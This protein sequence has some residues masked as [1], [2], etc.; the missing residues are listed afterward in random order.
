MKILSLNFLT[1]AVKACRATAASFP[2]HPRD[3][4]L[5]HDDLELNRPFLAN[6][7]RRVDWT[8]LRTTLIELGFP[9]LPEEAPSPEALEADEALLRELHNV[10]METE[11]VEGKLVCG[12]C[13]HEYGVR[14]GIANFL[15][16][17]HLV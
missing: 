11:I 15:L 17:S 2:L 9:P 4:E 8:A 14:E 6:I 12:N 5:A 13:G 3:A 7:V 16:P 10:L 1:C